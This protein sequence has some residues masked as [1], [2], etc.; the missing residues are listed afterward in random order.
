[1]S[2]RFS[3]NPRNSGG[4]RPP[5]QQAAQKRTVSTKVCRNSFC[6]MRHARQS[7]LPARFNPSYHSRFHRP[8]LRSKSDID[9]LAEAIDNRSADYPGEIIFEIFAQLR[10]DARDFVVAAATTDRQKLH[11]A[12][13][14]R[15]GM[16]I[17]ILGSGMRNSVMPQIE[18]IQ[19]DITQ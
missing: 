7:H 5:L 14:A 3:W 15:F 6:I 12:V 9:S 13:L 2:A 4:H 16:M 1:M 18:I 11:S 17:D 19:G 8:I 10:D